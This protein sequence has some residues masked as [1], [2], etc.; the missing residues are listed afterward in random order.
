[1]LHSRILIF[2]ILTFLFFSPVLAQETNTVATSTNPDVIFNNGLRELQKGNITTAISLL[3]KLLSYNTQNPCYYIY[4][5]YLYYVQGN[6]DKA[7][8]TIKKSLE[9]NDNLVIG[10]ILLGEIYYEKNS[11]LEARNEYEKVLQIN[12]GIK[13]AHIR[14][15]ELFKNN[16]PAKANKHYLE[17]FHLPPTKLEKYLPDIEKIGNIRLRFN[18]DVLILK[19]TVLDKK[20]AQDKTILDEIFKEETETTNKEKIIVSIKDRKFKLNF[21]FLLNPLKNFDKEKFYIKI[22]ELIFISLFLLVYS[23]FQRKKEKQ[24]E[25][26]VLAQYRVSNT[27]KEK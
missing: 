18:K 20:R 27:Q 11:I 5:G 25:R 22:I 16:N 21:K 19:N 26:V 9:F 12:P 1:M 10:H 13:K 14:L 6:Y 17:V 15:Y 24:L 7:V 4:L 8:H 3:E 2:F 23:L